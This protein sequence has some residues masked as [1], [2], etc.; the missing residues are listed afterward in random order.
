MNHLK[1]W[2]FVLLS[3]ALVSCGGG[4]GGGSDPAA[5]PTAAA[6]DPAQV[7][8]TNHAWL[9][10]EGALFK[11]SVAQSQSSLSAVAANSGSAVS[12]PSSDAT[13]AAAAP[14]TDT[15]AVA[16]SAV[17]APTIPAPVAVAASAAAPAAVAQVVALQKVSEM[18]VSRTVYD[19][20][21]K[22]MLASPN[23]DL[24]RAQ[25]VL[26]AAGPGTSV[27]SPV[28]YFGA[29]TPAATAVSDN[30]V[31]LRHDR[32][33]PFDLA[34][35]RWTV[36]TYVTPTQPAMALQVNQAELDPAVKLADGALTAD[37]VNPLILVDPTGNWGATVGTVL[38]FDGT[39]RRVLQVTVV[40]PARRLVTEELP[41]TAAFKQL[42]YRASLSPLADASMQAADPAQATPAKTGGTTNAF[43]RRYKQ[44]TVDPLFRSKLQ[45]AML[46]NCITPVPALEGE[47]GELTVKFEFDCAISDLAAAFGKT[48]PNVGRIY[49]NVEHTAKD[50]HVFSLA[51]KNDYV[52]SKVQV[53]SNLGIEISAA[54]A[55][56]EW[57]T[58]GGS[59]CEKTG[60]G[61]ECK[62][63]LMPLQ[64]F[65]RFFFFGG[66]PVPVTADLDLVIVVELAGSGG[67]KV[68]AEQS[69]TT[70]KGLRAGVKVEELGDVAG[71][72]PALQLQA[73]VVPSADFSA[74]AALGLDSNIDLG[75]LKFKALE[76]FA[77]LKEASLININVFAGGYA[78]AKPDLSANRTL[79]T[80][81]D[82]GIKAKGQVTLL[83]SDFL[84]KLGLDGLHLPEAEYHLPLL[85]KQSY[86]NDCAA[87]LDSERVNLIAK[88][89]G[90]E[91][92]A[93]NLSDSGAGLDVL[94]ASGQWLK[95]KVAHGQKFTID[96]TETLQK[97]PTFKNIVIEQVLDV[98]NFGVEGQFIR[99]GV[100]TEGVGGTYKYQFT[101]G[102]L[103]PGDKLRLRFRAYQAGKLQE[104]VT[105]RGM[106]IEFEIP[107]TA[108]PTYEFR[109][110]ATGQTSYLVNLNFMSDARGRVTSARIE[111]A[112]ATATAALDG[113]EGVAP[114]NWGY[115]QTGPASTA[116]VLNAQQELGG[117]SRLDQ[118][119][120]RPAFL[121]LETVATEG[122]SALYR[123]PIL[124]N[125]SPR[126]DNISFDK[127]AHLVLQTVKVAIRGGNL[128]PDLKLVMPWCVNV[129]EVDYDVEA[130]RIGN[131]YSNVER[132]FT[133][134]A[135]KAGERMPV[136]VLDGL[137][138]AVHVV[139]DPLG[140][141]TA[142]AGS[143]LVQG[144]TSSF[145]LVWARGADLFNNAAV[146][147]MWDFGQGVVSALVSI[148]DEVKTVFATAGDKVL[149]LVYS[150]FGETFA[151]LPT[152]TFNVQAG[153]AARIATVLPNV[154]TAGIAQTFEVTG[155]NLPQ[156]LHFNLPGCKGLVEILAGVSDAL[157]KFSC[158]FAVDTPAGDVDGTVAF[159]NNPFGAP[160]LKTFTVGVSRVALGPIAPANVMRTLA[161]SFEVSGKNLPTSGLSV[162]PV[163][164]GDDT[165]SNCQPPNN[166]TA[167]VFGVACEL[168]TLGAQV[169]QVKAGAAT[170]GSV[171]VNV[172]SNVSGVSWT[173]PSTAHSGTVRFGETVTF[174]VRGTNLRADRIM[175]FAVEKCGVS[176]AELP[177]ATNE[178]RHFS[179]LFNNEA[180]ATAGQMPGVVKDMPGGQVLLDGWVV[181]V[182]VPPQP[183]VV[184]TLLAHYPFDGSLADLV[185]PGGAGQLSVV[186][187]TPLFEAGRNGQAVALTP[188]TAVPGSYLRGEPLVTSD[189][190]FTVSAWVKPTV[191]DA[192]AVAALVFQRTDGG[193]ATPGCSAGAY[194]FGLSIYQGQW[195]FQVSTMDGP[196]CVYGDVFST[197][198]AV[199]G[200]YQHVAGVYD[201]AAGK[202]YL[203]VDGVLA[204]ERSVG[205][206]F[207]LTPNM[208]VTIG[209][210]PWASGYQPANAKMDDLKVFA[211]AL[212][213]AELGALVARGAAEI[214]QQVLA[215]SPEPGLRR[216]SGSP[217][218]HRV[219][220]M[221]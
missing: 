81:F 57:Q 66:V 92:Y 204:G 158:T 213:E 73:G 6:A 78:R 29:V 42:A 178:T 144:E 166:L 112:L 54:G 214:A 71:T 203:Y 67:F 24:A 161:A 197:A 101:P 97:N 62:F 179:C 12:A 35:L 99:S 36:S 212:S 182:E 88:L 185:R 157:R 108:Q 159:S 163:L 147:V 25:A 52:V 75:S 53:K 134:T 95:D 172:T 22:V 91:N 44:A 17:S 4:G 45:A 171:T 94:S 211:G 208:V 76:G 176:N 113:V 114:V 194:N 15:G 90:A 11:L 156:G 215:I 9:D 13:S 98:A 150:I 72:K 120:A 162:V 64:H 59:G 142:Y 19:Y 160:A 21:F 126:V 117:A 196:N 119:V 131:E 109:R 51:D 133:C 221:P 2:L 198:T 122:V 5:S 63:K 86:P 188:S 40:G 116:W 216:A 145:G 68:Y 169:L 60:T 140:F 200:R 20:T 1:R 187:S 34:A 110:T 87:T 152:Q 32:T 143:P 103:Q 37:P 170:L 184:H 82:A 28:A 153:S 206:N 31:T 199:A 70:T 27:L 195:L 219:A 130:R 14:G 202:A 48:I 65:M 207:R 125:D 151:T 8:A 96:L 58:T 107:P 149:Q 115:E 84:A 18:R 79:C 220:T 10:A 43:G 105:L 23:K 205:P 136:S 183:P 39:V 41:F 33:V 129:Q 175:G 135:T 50:E 85:W 111:R 93:V 201:Q 30:T 89:D 181:P 124:V 123:I 146:Q 209:N 217:I 167:N 3:A 121:L 137:G 69:R 138:A 102:R 16:V 177:G 141:P 193:G 61:T 189:T 7:L 26:M 148:Y 218:A 80:K 155:S 180:G 168:Y 127:R 192:A 164:R 49:G 38:R 132:F 118:P 128:P 173:S 83:K 104:T 100:N 47:T 190:S 55:L 191:V 46:V 106:R 77:S 139:E 165:R 74:E 186:G 154:A 56:P 174:T 210:Q